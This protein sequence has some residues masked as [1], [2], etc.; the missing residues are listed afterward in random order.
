[1]QRP[2]QESEMTLPARPTEAALPAPLNIRS[3]RQ[4][5]SRAE[6]DV[7]DFDRL[8][9]PT[10]GVDDTPYIRFAIEQITFDEE[11]MGRGRHSSECYQTPAATRQPSDDQPAQNPQPQPQPNPQREPPRR[12]MQFPRASSDHRRGRAGEVML[13][14]SDPPRERHQLGFV[15]IPLRIISLGPLVFLCLLI[16]VAL[17][18]SNVYALTNHGLYDYDTNTSARYFVFQYLPPLLGMIIIFWLFVVQA[19][20]YRIMPYF[21]MSKKGPSTRRDRTLQTMPITPANF[22][23]PDWRFFQMGEPL[24]GAV[25][26]I[27]WL[28]YWTIPLLSCLYGT[29]WFTNVGAPR[30]RWTPVQ[31]LGWFIMVQYLVLIVALVMCMIRFRK[32][33][34]ALMWDP[35]SLADLIILFQRSNILPDYIQSETKEHMRTELPPR[36]C[37]LGYWTTNQ[38][39]DFFYAVGEANQPFLELSTSFEPSANEKVESTR[40]SGESQAELRYSQAS[41]FLRMLHSPW[42][43]YRWCPWFL[44]DGAILAW[45]I[46]AVL[47]LIAFLVVSFVNKAVGRG[48]FA[49]LPATTQANGF[50][51][52]NFLYSFVP[53]L[54]GMFLFLAWQPIDVY[55]RSVQSYAN[56]SE[57]TGATARRSILLSYNAMLPGLVALRALMNGDIKVAYM[58]FISIMAA[59]IPVLAGGVFTALLFS[60]GEVRMTASMPGYIALCVF[61]SIYALSYLVVWPTRYRYLP[62][63]IDTVAGNVSFLYASRL[64]KDSSIRNIRTKAD[65]IARLDGRVGTTLTGDG[66]RRRRQNEKDTD[67][68]A[69]YGFGIYTGIDGKEHLGIDRMQRPGSGEMLVTTGVGGRQG[70]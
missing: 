51:P 57:Q 34:S 65:F 58:S 52:A 22:V 4:E 33:N 18:F 25:L 20:I 29:Q 12:P 46:A 47:L 19:A 66:H 38:S 70:R 41:S 50:S 45:A 3:N 6:R 10:P 24:I 60:N 63:S 69:R 54:L 21:S 27:F 16:V 49:L 28:T 44:R 14:P 13:L 36:Y 62:H 8:S 67:R 43:R 11:L 32:R 39:P 40:T 59:T 15:P 9:P 2:M 30:F 23:L 56:L 55:F 37:R 7:P 31:G 5:R 1:M 68:E 17:I 48:F 26:T 64:L 53:S 61:T 35:T 42:V